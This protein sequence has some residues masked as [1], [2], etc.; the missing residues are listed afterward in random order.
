MDSTISP[1]EEHE[2]QLRKHF[3]ISG[4]TALAH[5]LKA[6]KVHTI[7]LTDMADED[8]ALLGVERACDAADALEKAG[9]YLASGRSLCYIMPEGYCTLPLVN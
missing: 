9:A 5:R 6:A 8:A 4:H 3:E 1:I 2:K 7:I